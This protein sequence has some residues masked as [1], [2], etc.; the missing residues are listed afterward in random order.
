MKFISTLLSIYKNIINIYIYTKSNIR[1]NTYNKKYI[2]IFYCFL[3]YER[4]GRI[5][6]Y[7]RESV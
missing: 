5:I 7:V 6:S 4:Y 2:Y 1:C 3:G